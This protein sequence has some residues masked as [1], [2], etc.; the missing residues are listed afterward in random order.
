MF[1]LTMYTLSGIK[2][3]FLSLIW[4]LSNGKRSI[5]KKLQENGYRKPLLS[6]LPVRPCRFCLPHGQNLCQR[7]FSHKVPI[8]FMESSIRT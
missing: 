4:I 6:L 3:V 5:N 1:L 7:L 2:A 8:Y